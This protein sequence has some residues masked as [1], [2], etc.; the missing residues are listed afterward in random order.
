M[1][2]RR[3]GRSLGFSSTLSMPSRA[4][5]SA[6]RTTDGLKAAEMLTKMCGWNEPERV[7]VQSVEVKV[8]AALIKQLR[9]GYAQ[10]SARR[11]SQGGCWRPAG[12]KK[13]RRLLLVPPADRSHYGCL[14]LRRDCRS[15]HL[16]QRI[17]GPAT[18]LRF[19]NPAACGEARLANFRHFL[20]LTGTFSITISLTTNIDLLFLCLHRY[21]VPAE[22]VRVVLRRYILDLSGLDA[23]LLVPRR[24]DSCPSL[25]RSCESALRVINTS[26]KPI[27][28]PTK[29][30]TVSPTRLTCLK[31]KGQS[32]LFSRMATVA[33]VLQI[34]S[35]SKIALLVLNLQDQ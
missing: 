19:L 27:L 31:I 21:S 23:A 18:V 22:S 7:N 14:L 10:M 13:R 30:P 5:L 16:A 32:R 33:E 25:R 1:A 11:A 2:P 9:A 12:A 34:A 6:A 15:S 26:R 4:R 20:V 29:G 3:Q 8:N 35:R 17:S 28:M 24:R